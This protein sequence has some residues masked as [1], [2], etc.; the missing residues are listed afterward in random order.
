MKPTQEQIDRL[1]LLSRGGFNILS[2]RDQVAL[3]ALIEYAGLT[4]TPVDYSDLPEVEAVR[5]A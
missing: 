5:V 1:Y 3:D 2:A 4:P